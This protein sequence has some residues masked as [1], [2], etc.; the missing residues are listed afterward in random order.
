MARY[1]KI[2][3]LDWATFER[4]TEEKFGDD[5]QE[6]IVYAEDGNLHIAVDEDKIDTVHFPP[7][8]LDES[9]VKK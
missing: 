9:E 5:Y 3:K 2:E 4:L 8:A 7:N 1:F 6:L